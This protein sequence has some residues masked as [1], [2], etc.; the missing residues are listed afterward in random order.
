MAKPSI[1]KQKLQRYL[2]KRQVKTVVGNKANWGPNINIAL[3]PIG[4]HV[5]KLS[6]MS[7]FWRSFL[8][9]IFLLYLYNL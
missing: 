2:H 9:I 1:E 4:M 7:S 8:S 6:I 3:M 5:Y